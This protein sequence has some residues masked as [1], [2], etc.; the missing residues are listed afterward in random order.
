V[1]ETAPLPSESEETMATELARRLFGTGVVSLWRARA[2]VLAATDGGRRVPDAPD[3]DDAIDPKTLPSAARYG[4]GDRMLA[5]IDQDGFAFAVNLEDR[6][7]FN[8]RETN[9]PRW[10]HKMDVVLHAGRICVRKR[11]RA[12]SLGARRFGHIKNT[13]A[14]QARWHAWAALGLS[15]Y[16][17]SA[18]LLRLA[19]LPF[20]PKLRGIDVSRRQVFM[21]YL[22]GE[23]LRQ[24]AAA[25]GQPIYDADIGADPTFRGLSSEE[26]TAREVSLVDAAGLGNYRAEVHRM[27]A[28]MNENGVA[29]LDIKP[30]N[31]LRGLKTKRL[32]WLDFERARLRSH[33]RWEA[34][35]Q[36]QHEL[37]QSLFGKPS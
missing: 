17:E 6:P 24:V 2:E 8:R 16:M 29:P 31:L 1:I 26:L 4:L 12:P 9:L 21:D 37:L 18:A 25:Q 27:V 20:V 30:G 7:L 36:T 13:L 32:Y 34:E 3:V 23:S 33:P 5:E 19:A 11:F 10:V 15:F 22:P 14:E 35:L 28:A